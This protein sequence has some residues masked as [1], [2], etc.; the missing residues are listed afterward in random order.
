MT[1]DQREAQ[2]LD[3]SQGGN[4]GAASAL[5]ALG[6]LRYDKLS[7]RRGAITAWQEY[8]D[9][10]PHGALLGDVHVA[11]FEALLADN[12]PADA[13]SHG[14]AALASNLSSLRRQK[15]RL[16]VAEVLLLTL[17]EAAK[18]K[19]HLLQLVGRTGPVGER[20]TFLL[21][22]AYAQLDEHQ[23]A[24]ETV[25]TYLERYPEGRYRKQ[26]EEALDPI[27]AEEN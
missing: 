21:A 27:N 22:T 8:V 1:L 20:A 13:V 10:F 25:K 4:E 18:A 3:L 11:L 9:R 15:L 19:G 17:N 6:A 7:N 12:A 26:A 16:E 23:L 14:E 24:H 2:F 5:F